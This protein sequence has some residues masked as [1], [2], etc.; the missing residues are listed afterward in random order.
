MIISACKYVI[1]AIGKIYEKG[2]ADSSRM[3]Q[4]ILLQLSD[5]GELKC[6]E[7]A[8]LPECAGVEMNSLVRHIAMKNQRRPD[9]Y[10]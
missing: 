8:K 2:E 5:R 6:R 1:S 4:A 7:I 3:R 10:I 9:L